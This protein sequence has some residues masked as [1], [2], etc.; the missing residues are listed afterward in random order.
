MTTTTTIYND[1]PFFF[2]LV[3]RDDAFLLTYVLSDH[4]HRAK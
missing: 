4:C 3:S 2:F 1:F